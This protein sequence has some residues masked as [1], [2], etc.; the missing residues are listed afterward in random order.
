M[1]PQEVGPCRDSVPAWFYDHLTGQCTYFIYG[2]CQGNQNNFLSQ[3]ECERTC[4]REGESH[5]TCVSSKTY[6]RVQ[7]STPE[8]ETCRK[9]AGVYNY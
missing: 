1:Q 2:G 4:S 6:T 8:A 5:S 7:R 9:L 3:D